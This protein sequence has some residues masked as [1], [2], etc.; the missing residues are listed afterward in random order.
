M[1]PTVLGARH[2]W[3]GTWLGETPQ[4]MRE[5]VTFTDPA[6]FTDLQAADLVCRQSKAKNGYDDATTQEKHGETPSRKLW[7]I[8]DS[9]LQQT[10]VRH[11]YVRNC[12]RLGLTSW[13][14][15]CHQ[16]F[17]VWCRPHAPLR[18]SRRKTKILQWRIIVRHGVETSRKW[19]SAS[20]FAKVAS[21]LSN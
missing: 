7:I 11:L 13:R 18:R 2:W 19:S 15:P 20:E 14:G 9:D 8:S 16:K 21:V 1:K 17:L 3:K 5:P 10:P 6:T 12:T 4:E